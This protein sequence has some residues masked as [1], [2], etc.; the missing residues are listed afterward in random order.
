MSKPDILQENP[1]KL[2]QKIRS[3]EDICNNGK[4]EALDLIIKPI[5]TNN[6]SYDIESLAL[7]NSKAVKELVALIE[8]STTIETKQL[9]IHC[10]SEKLIV[11]KNLND[12]II[13]QILEPIYKII[14][15]PFVQEIEKGEKNCRMTKLFI[16]SLAIAHRMVSVC[17]TKKQQRILFQPDLIEDVINCIQ[18]HLLNKKEKIDNNSSVEGCLVECVG[19]LAALASKMRPAIRKLQEKNFCNIFSNEAVVIRKK[20]LKPSQSSFLSALHTKSFSKPIDEGLNLLKDNRLTLLC[21]ELLIYDISRKNREKFLMYVVE[22]LSALTEGDETWSHVHRITMAKEEVVK[23]LAKLLKRGCGEELVVK[24]VGLI[25]NLNKSVM[26]QPLITKFLMRDLVGMLLLGEN[27]RESPRCLVETLQTLSELLNNAINRNENVKVFAENCG[28]HVVMFLSTR[29]RKV[30][31][32]RVRGAAFDL[33]QLMW[34]NSRELLASFGYVRPVHEVSQ[35]DRQI[36][37]DSTFS[38]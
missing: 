24:T 28:V 9:A 37:L 23:S 16:T 8:P 10:I 33:L 31:N 4:I 6:I 38:T 11:N 17:E 13:T 20:K 36:S 32:E 14:I 18:L 29:N 1:I 27:F 35:H 7:N 21:C 26:N 22:L 3:S 2:E 30:D 15:S 5:L 19:F 25:S 12:E 34:K